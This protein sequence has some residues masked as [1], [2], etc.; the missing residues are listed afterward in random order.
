MR[1]VA[2]ATSAVVARLF[3]DFAEAAREAG[4]REDVIRVHIRLRFQLGNEGVATSPSRDHFFRSLI[5]FA[6]AAAIG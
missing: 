6:V 5:V 1:P 2:T 3:E 4:V